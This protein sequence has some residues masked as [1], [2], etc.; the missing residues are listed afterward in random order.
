MPF[1]SACG[2][3]NAKLRFEAHKAFVVKFHLTIER[4]MRISLPFVLLA[5]H[6]GTGVL[7]L[8]LT[9]SPKVQKNFFRFCAWLAGALIGLT[10]PFRYQPRF[11]E[12]TTFAMTVL[13]LVTLT[14]YLAA[15]WS[16]RL[17]WAR[18]FLL[19]S[20]MT[21]ILTTGLDMEALKRLTGFAAAPP[22]LYTSFFL[23]S[24]LL[25]SS[26]MA[27]LIGHWYVMDTAMSIEHLKKLSTFFTTAAAVR[28]LL[29]VGALT[30]YWTQGSYSQDAVMRLMDPMAD[31][32]IFWFR[33]V[34]GLLG[35][36]VL[37][38]FVGRTVNMRSTLSATGLLY[39]AV[40]FVL[41][42]EL[43]S[44]YLLTTSSIPV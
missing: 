33:M 40:I 44:K 7:L 32:L 1:L 43:L 8:M 20:A 34:I 26:M 2:P 36:L 39:V 3:P 41:F 38:L 16:G 35:P 17:G 13:C 23:S 5:T 15:L 10:L 24:L 4:L 25:G 21:A 37:A 22:L 14:A 30:Y 29:A 6:L 12:P 19:V 28:V 27:M 31:G 42:G 9:V 11:F 18:N